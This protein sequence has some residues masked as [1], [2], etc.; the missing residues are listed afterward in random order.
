MVTLMGKT[1]EAVRKTLAAVDAPLYDIGILTDRGM[2]PRMEALSASQCMNRLSYLKYR[3]ANGAH[4]YFR[5]SGERSFI[6]LDDLDRAALRKLTAA[7]FGPCAV[8]ET[9]PGN[10]QAWL[11]HTTILSKELGTLAAQTLAR[12]YG[13]DPG[14]ADWRRF[15]RLPGF[16]NRK[17]QRRSA[18]GFFPFVRLHSH[19]GQQFTSAESFEH[20]IISLQRFREAGGAASKVQAL[21]RTRIG[22]LSL[23]VPRRT[24]VPGPTG[25]RRHGLLDSRVCERMVAD[26]DCR[27]PRLRVPL[28]RS[29]S[30]QTSGLCSQNHS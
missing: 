13:A 25:C 24:E 28:A 8:I 21:E 17:P 16:T 30:L 9:S 4:I 14:A 27:C 11:R 10:Y 18:D 3:N 15:G 12:R 7:G 1:E 26:P 22:P 23:P 19:T 20:E 6:V 5:P 2:F 29:Q